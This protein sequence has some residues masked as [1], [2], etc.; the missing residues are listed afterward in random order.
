MISVGWLRLARSADVGRTV[1]TWPLESGDRPQTV[2]LW[3]TRS[4]RVVAIDGRC[5]HRGYPMTGA[6][7]VGDAIECPRHEFRFAPNGRCVNM[8]RAAPARVLDIRESDGYVWLADP[9]A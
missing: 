9:A 8:R 3:R 5:P 4:G 1:V 7:I 2:L 6:R